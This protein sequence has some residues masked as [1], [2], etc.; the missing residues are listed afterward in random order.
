MFS[1]VAGNSN[2]VVQKAKEVLFKVESSYRE[3]ACS[4]Y[5]PIMDFIDLMKIIGVAVST[6]IIYRLFVHE[7]RDK[8]KGHYTRPGG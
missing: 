1:V 2:I 8:T 4:F 3:E 5:Q 7:S 6:F